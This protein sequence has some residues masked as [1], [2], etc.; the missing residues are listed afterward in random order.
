MRM[1]ARLPCTCRTILP[2]LHKKYLAA[3]LDMFGDCAL[4]GSAQLDKAA[5]VRRLKGRMAFDWLF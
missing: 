1:P 4:H 2:A 5:K 3:M